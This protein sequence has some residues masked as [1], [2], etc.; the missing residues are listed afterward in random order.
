[1]TQPTADSPEQSTTDRGQ[2]IAAI[3]LG[4]AA[5]LT[6][7]ASYSSSLAGGDAANLRTDAG[8]T[9][10]DANFFYSQANQVSAGDQALFI[11]YAAANEQ[12]NTNLSQYLITLMRA[13]MQESIDWWLE[14]EDAVTPFD[15]LDGNP[16]LLEDL[17]DANALEATAEDQVDRS[18]AADDKASQFDLATVL[19]ALTLFFAGIATL[20][21]RR[22]I[23]RLLLGVSVVTLVVGSVILGQNLPA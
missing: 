2:L 9:L 3:V 14:T 21:R 23:P 5:V 17:A 8:R 18:Q 19:L 11:A 7:L 22:G 12:G 15:D 1:V 13:P 16:Y 6:A 10:A 4:L 20:F